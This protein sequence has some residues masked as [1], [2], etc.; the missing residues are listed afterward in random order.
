MLRSWK[1]F[2]VLVAFVA[3]AVS[4][5]SQIE[6]PKRID[7][8]APFIP[9][10]EAARLS[11]VGFHTA[12]ADFYWLRAVQV[13]GSVDH[14]EHHGTLLGR[15]IDVVTRVDPWVGHPYRFAAVWMTKS[16]E[17]VRQANMLLKRSLDY[18][19]E[20]WRNRFYLGF[21]LFYYLEEPEEA[22]IYFEE[23][24]RLPGS[25]RYLMGLVARLRAGT[26]GLD[27]AAGLIREMWEG[28]EDPQQ[29]AEFEKMLEEIHTERLARMLDQARERY[30][31]RF[32]RDIER[33]EELL[34][35][36]PPVLAKLPPEPHGWEWVIHDETGEIVSSW[37]DHRYRP[38]YD[39]EIRAEMGGW[40]AQGK[41]DSPAG[42]EG[43][44]RGATSEREAQE[45]GT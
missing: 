8:G 33:V 39:P 6:I 31:T 4:F 40:R 14:P 36:D 3:A 38:H 11:S 37:Y 45:E 42:E 16:E 22:A 34:E 19:P 7:Q 27:V 20:E 2:V 28:S 9:R 25:P 17:D 44:A 35:G 1:G 13:V 29:R 24:A 30:R 41:G 26:A 18:H 43:G 5:H 12:M 32:G 23:A 21:N 10:P 15:F